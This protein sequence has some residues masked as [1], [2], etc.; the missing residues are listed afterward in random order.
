VSKNLENIKI[1]KKKTHKIQKQIK[2]TKK[3]N[4]VEVEI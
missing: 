3:K 2:N 4:I 1:Q